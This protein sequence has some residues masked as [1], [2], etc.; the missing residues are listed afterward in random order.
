MTDLRTRNR[1][2]NRA[3][4]ARVAL[5]LFV[6]RGFDDVTVDDIAEAAGISRRTFFRYFE[7][8]EDA[9]L[10]E[11]HERLEALRAALSA[12]PAGEP[13]V[14]GLRH[15]TSALLGPDHFD[16]DEAMAR[17][18]IVVENPSVHARSLELQTHWETEIRQVIAEHRGVDADTDVA[19]RVL[20][21][22]TVAS[23]RAA[24]EVWL[25]TGGDR[26]LVDVL[27]EAYDVL[28]GDAFATD[29]GA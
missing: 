29:P 1:E 2:Q 19:A 12:R 15:A 17:L 6:A 7:S 21:A 28:M 5:G 9:A 14:L 11:E 8:K 20:A 25:L 26:P 13:L 4:V 10:P 23:F 24:A 16:P 18:R 3:D 27:A 22:A